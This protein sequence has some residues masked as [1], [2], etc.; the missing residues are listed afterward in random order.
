[1][2][3]AT[4]AKQIGRTVAYSLAA[5][6][7][8][9]A[10]GRELGDEDTVLLAAAASEMHPA[11]VLKGIRTRSVTEALAAA[12]GRARAAGVS[13]L[14]AITVGTQLFSG[15]LAVEQASGAMARSR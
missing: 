9:F 11:S 3:A 12:N 4:Y 1:M 10:G 15:A 2:L 14:P 5:F 6:R 8:T 7:Q 13:V